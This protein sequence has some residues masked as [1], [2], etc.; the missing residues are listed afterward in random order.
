MQEQ[1]YVISKKRTVRKVYWGRII[2]VSVALCA[3]IIGMTLFL[4][5]TKGSIT[6]DART[7][8]LVSMGEYNDSN[9]A[10][11][12]ADEVR[13]AGGA[14]YIYGDKSFVVAASCYAS[15][16]DARTVSSRIDGSG[17]YAI[18]CPALTVSKPKKG[19][20]KLKE[21]LALP[22]KIFDELYDIS[23]KLDTLQIAESAAKYAVLKLSV[24]CATYASQCVEIEGEA[25]SYL[26]GLLSFFAEKTEN[27]A[28]G[29]DAGQGIKYA[30]CE[31]AVKTCKAGEEFNSSAKK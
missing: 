1:P 6:V 16:D 12:R 11:A 23:V 30:L 7:Y 18:S 20:A 22:A 21:M 5:R 29:G 25:G 26:Y 24:A 28:S 4:T 27:V 13:L 17:V 8:W 9:S 2:A 15:E 10:T 3:L 31:F 19:K 14:G